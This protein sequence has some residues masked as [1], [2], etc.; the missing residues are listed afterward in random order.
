MMVLLS[1]MRA[2]ISSSLSFAS[3]ASDVPVAAAASVFCFASALSTAAAASDA[4]A[5]AASAS[6]T[7]LFPATLVAE[8]HGSNIAVRG[9]MCT[10]YNT[11]VGELEAP[12]QKSRSNP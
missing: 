8:W 6:F 12:A 9:F 11:V 10:R 7:F 2:R 1:C 3:F 4:A 5:F